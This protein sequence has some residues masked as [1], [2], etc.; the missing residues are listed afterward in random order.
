M[1]QYQNCRVAPRQSRVQGQIE[2]E[3]S[4]MYYAADSKLALV[5]LPVLVW[6]LFRGTY[7]LVPCNYDFRNAS[8]ADNPI[9]Q[10]I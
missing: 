3:L 4:E 9:L 5:F 1:V 10:S 6:A 8:C 2:S 7:D